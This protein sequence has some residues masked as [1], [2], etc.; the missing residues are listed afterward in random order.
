[1]KIGGTAKFAFSAEKAWKM[2]E[3]L[4]VNGMTGTATGSVKEAGMSCPVT[5]VLPELR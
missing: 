2:A 3:K 5:A 4:S 1:M